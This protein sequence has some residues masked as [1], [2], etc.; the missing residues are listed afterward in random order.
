MYP[1]LPFAISSWYHQW[2]YARTPSQLVTNPRTFTDWS[3]MA[4]ERHRPPK[5]RAV[6]PVECG[7]LVKLLLPAW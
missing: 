3:R 6:I 1:R 2:S 7:I 5:T 4:L